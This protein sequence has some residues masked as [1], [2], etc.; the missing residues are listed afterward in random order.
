MLIDDEKLSA[1][2]DNELSDAEAQLVRDQIAIDESLAA[3]L[4]AL[5]MADQQVN[6]YVDELNKSPLPQRIDDL[7]NDDNS[8][9]VVRL[10]TWQRPPKTNRY[11]ALAASVALVIGFTAGQ[12]FTFSGQPDLERQIAQVLELQPSGNSYQIG[13]NFEVL[14]RLT[15]KNSQGDF[16]RQ[17]M[18]HQQGANVATEAIHCRR[19]GEWQ[20]IAELEVPFQSRQGYQTASGGSVLDPILDQVMSSSAFTYSEEQQSLN[21]QWQQ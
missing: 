7:L 2:L 10:K 17:S 4:A 3:R 12:W 21:T 18:V 13:N 11:L 6:D 19:Q 9:N 15:F 16:C 14:P 5:V 1:F 8:A 20:A